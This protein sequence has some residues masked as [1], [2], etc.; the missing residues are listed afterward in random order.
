MLFAEGIYPMAKKS[1]VGTL[2]L[3]AR[4]LPTVQAYLDQP[5][6][7]VTTETST[8][9]CNEELGTSEKTVPE[10]PSPA[11]KSLDFLCTDPLP[12]QCHPEY[13]SNSS[14]L[15]KSHVTSYS[16][17]PNAFSA[18]NQALA[19]QR[20][21]YGAQALQQ[22]RMMNMMGQAL[23]GWQLMQQSQPWGQ[24][25]MMM[26]GYQPILQAFPQILKR[27]IGL[28]T[29]QSGDDQENLVS[30][31]SDNGPEFIAKDVADFF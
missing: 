17:G 3:C 11:P 2:R 5:E 23:Q 12:P 31:K 14:F 28:R 6:R 18:S 22:A 21:S 25:P 24:F 30:A 26:P 1:A 20:W 9:D 7:P 19:M 27:T 4:G 8:Q 29:L 10:S 15:D 16:P 13:R